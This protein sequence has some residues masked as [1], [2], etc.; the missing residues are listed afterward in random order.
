MPTTC[1]VN[2]TVCGSNKKLPSLQRS[3]KICPRMKR[4]KNQS[5]PTQIFKL[6]AGTLSQCLEWYSY[7]LKSYTEGK[8]KED[9]QIELVER[10]SILSDMKVI[11][12]GINGILDIAK[13]KIGDLKDKAIKNYPK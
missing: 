7:G 12:D 9:T 13:E 4:K 1:K 8:Q 6:V 3:R 5:R 11:L 2:F 10:K